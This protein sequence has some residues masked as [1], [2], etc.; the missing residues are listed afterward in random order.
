[1]GD[2][3]SVNGFTPDRIAIAIVWAERYE[4]RGWRCLPSRCDDKRPLLPTYAHLWE[5]PFPSVRELWERHPSGNIQL[6]TGRR[7][8]LVVVDVD[9]PDAIQAWKKLFDERGAS[10]PRTWISSRD[11]REGRHYWFTLPRPLRMGPYMGKRLLWGVWEP[12]ANG[13]RGAWRKRAGIEL[14]AD[15]SLVM[16]PPS[17]HPATGQIYRWHRGNDP[18]SLPH[19]PA[20]FPHWLVELDAAEDC[21]PRNITPVL[22]SPRLEPKPVRIDGELMLPAA[23]SVIRG[24]LP[25]LRIVERDWGVRIVSYRTNYEGWMKARKIGVEDRN[26]SAMFNPVTG[27]FWQPEGFPPMVGEERSICLF[28]LGV[29]LGRYAT[30]KECAYDLARKIGRAHV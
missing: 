19:G 29:W 27:R 8:G 28:G 23:P 15:K 20:Q 22:Y 3:G 21:R 26:P 30:W 10:I 9:G 24:M 14:L 18:L 2:M 12:E 25:K 6:M 4:G 7:A 17:I 1:M 5:G 13:G 11:E 16:A